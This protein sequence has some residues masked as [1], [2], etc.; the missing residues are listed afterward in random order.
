V[1]N[2]S[3]LAPR[4][5]LPLLILCSVPDP[6][7][8]PAQ[9]CNRVPPGG[10]AVIIP[11]STYLSSARRRII[12]HRICNHAI[13]LGEHSSHGYDGPPRRAAA[14][15]DHRVLPGS[16]DHSFCSYLL[17]RL[18]TD[19]LSPQGK[20]LIAPRAPDTTTQAILLFLSVSAL[21]QFLEFAPM[22][23]GWRPAPTKS[24][25]FFPVTT[26]VVITDTVCWPAALFLARRGRT[27]RGDWLLD[28]MARLQI[29]SS[30]L[31]GLGSV[32]RKCTIVSSLSFTGGLM[33]L[34]TRLED[35]PDA[36]RAWMV[37]Q[38]PVGSPGDHTHA[39]RGR[40]CSIPPA[41]LGLGM[42]AHHPCI[43]HAC[44]ENTL[45]APRSA[46]SFS[47]WRRTSAPLKPVPQ[48]RP[49]G[50]RTYDECCGVA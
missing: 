30:V 42:V 5:G 8:T 37:R 35:G 44:Y 14:L 21:P 3:S 39:P 32:T 10:H 22:L 9:S 24:P 13:H 29:A 19:V 31:L 1:T 41:V 15:S 18:P 4:C 28:T 47:A 26:F 50:F 23:L 12:L 40:I 6:L 25:L 48:A 38:D 11:I 7:P 17:A 49:S 45:W 2:H 46:F 20:A 33:M 36:P 43:A 16:S 34:R 27:G